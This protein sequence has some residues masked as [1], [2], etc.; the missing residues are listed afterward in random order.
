M[1]SDQIDI[2]SVLGGFKIESEL[3]R[4]GMGVVY[5]AHELS[6][7]RKIALKVLSERLSSDEEFVKRFKRE[8]RVVAALSHPNIINILSYG[9]EGGRYYFAMEL[10]DGTDLGTILKKKKEI[11]LV[12]ALSITIQIADALGEASVH[13]VVHRDLKPSNIMIDDQGRVKV[14]DF[15]I[16]FFQDN[17]T[18]L[19]RTGLY[20]GTPEYSSPEQARG[21]KLDVRSDIF[22]L[23]AM[24]YKMLSGVPFV[25]GESPLA[26]MARIITEPVPAIAELKPSLPPLVCELVD[27]MMA[28]EVGA[29][30][31]TPAEVIEKA[32][33]CLADLNAGAPAK[34]SSNAP[35]PPSA[36]KSA[37]PPDV[38]KESRLNSRFIGAVAGIILAVL[39]SMWGVDAWINKDRGKEA[40]IEK[41]L[42]EKLPQLTPSL[43]GEPVAVEDGKGEKSVQP[44][45][46]SQEKDVT[47]GPENHGL[48]VADREETV[49]PVVVPELPK[50][51]PLLEAASP[52]P[53]ALPEIP[54]VLMFVS[55]DQGFL[56]FVRADLEALLVEN[57]LK[58]AA[59]AEIPVMTRKMQMG[60]T[61]F[62]WH[63]IKQFVPKGKANIILLAEVHKTDSMPLKFYGRSQD[64]TIV[65]FSVRTVDMGNGVS[66]AQPVAGTA[67][68][69]PLNIDD[70]LGQA[71]NSAASGIG[72]AIKNYWHRKL[73]KGRRARSMAGY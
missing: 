20:M 62:T 50:T 68:F 39:L 47:A 48:E 56:P 71:I 73:E 69:T 5:K 14:T 67:R 31:Q 43:S 70:K 22:S 58:T 35:P 38:K 52:R 23:G 55:G 2:G 53:P 30:F 37:T 34:E 4:G 64:M 17:E 60:N 66:V 1:N 29:R 33:K 26:V 10:L 7:N 40:V 6:L 15:G 51:L 61:A 65:S 19:T 28:K 18:H 41:T 72:P 25:S 49:S 27:R 54:T 3:G 12:D 59:I 45:D 32:K 11:P 16:A 46:A 44:K 21:E 8:A 9:E 24:L 13:G 63:D 42:S 57:G 36:D